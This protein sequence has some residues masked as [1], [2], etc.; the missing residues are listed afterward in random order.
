MK[1][2]LIKRW[3]TCVRSRLHQ[4]IDC[5]NVSLLELTQNVSEITTMVSSDLHSRNCGEI[6]KCTG[7]G[8]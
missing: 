7:L 3:H 1:Y 6:G 4:Y 5:R 2:F 8:L